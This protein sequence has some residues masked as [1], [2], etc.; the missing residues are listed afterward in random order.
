MDRLRQLYDQLEFPQKL[1]L[2]EGIK[3]LLTAAKLDFIKHCEALPEGHAGHFMLLEPSANIQHLTQAI[4]LALPEVRRQKE[5][6]SL[7]VWEQLE[8]YDRG[9]LRRYE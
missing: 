4:A 2:L 8:K 9:E 1:E 7:S 6:A 5:N 3:D